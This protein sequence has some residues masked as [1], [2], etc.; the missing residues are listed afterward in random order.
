MIMRAALL[1]PPLLL[2]G[3]SV[4]NVAAQQS[5]LGGRFQTT[6]D[7]QGILN[8]SLDVRDMKAASGKAAKLDIY[9]NVRFVM[10]DGMLLH[11]I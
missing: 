2:L 8:F 9:S 10:F 1:L 5:L 6:T 4:S 11:T 7:V 3:G